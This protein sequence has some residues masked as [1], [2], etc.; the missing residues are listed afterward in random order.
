VDAHGFNEREEQV[1]SKP[2]PLTGPFL[3]QGAENVLEPSFT[4]RLHERDY[5]L[6][7]R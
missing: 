7:H 6:E 5:A 4:R 2:N 1:A 3:V